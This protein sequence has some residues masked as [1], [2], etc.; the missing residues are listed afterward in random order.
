[1]Y[2]TTGRANERS[3]MGNTLKAAFGDLEK[4]REGCQQVYSGKGGIGEFVI[5]MD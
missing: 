1:M 5:E 3:H 2:K 4:V